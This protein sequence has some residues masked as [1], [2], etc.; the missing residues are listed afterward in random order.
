VLTAANRAGDGFLSLRTAHQAAAATPAAAATAVTITSSGVDTILSLFSGTC[1]DGI[2]SV[3]NDDND[4][5]GSYGSQI[6][7]NLTANTSY[8]LIVDGW[9]SNDNGMVTITVER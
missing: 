6:Q 3:C 9:T 5:P 1:P 7:A 2:L 8:Y 4:P